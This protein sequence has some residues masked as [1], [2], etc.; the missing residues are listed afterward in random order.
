MTI[1]LDI[2]NEVV[3]LAYGERLSVG[4]IARVLGVHPAVVERVLERVATGDD[5]RPPQGE[6]VAHLQLKELLS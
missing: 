1:A 3:R 6:V 4:V 5:R 2:A